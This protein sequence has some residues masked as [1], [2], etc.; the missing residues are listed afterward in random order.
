MTWQPLTDPAALPAEGNVETWAPEIRRRAP[1]SVYALREAL[2]LQVGK[3]P[4]WV[5]LITGWRVV[6]GDDGKA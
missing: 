6:E 3:R 1:C 2:A 4:Y 5:E